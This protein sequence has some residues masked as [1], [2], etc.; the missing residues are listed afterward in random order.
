MEKF[1]HVKH[2]DLTGH[3]YVFLGNGMPSGGLTG[4]VTFAPNFHPMSRLTSLSINVTGLHWVC[5]IFI[6]RLLELETLTLVGPPAHPDRA[7]TTEYTRWWEN[8]FESSLKH[9]ICQEPILT[10]PIEKDFDYFALFAHACPNLETFKAIGKNNTV[11]KFDHRS[12]LRDFFEENGVRPLK[13]LEIWDH[14][15]DVETRAQTVHEKDFAHQAMESFRK[16]NHVERLKLDLEILVDTPEVEEVP[17]LEDQSGFF[18][19][20]SVFGPRYSHDP[21]GG[22]RAFMLNLELPKAVQSLCLREVEGRYQVSRTLVRVLKE[23]VHGNSNMDESFPAIRRLQVESVSSWL[24]VQILRLRQRFAEKGVELMALSLDGKTI[25]DETELGPVDWPVRDP[26]A[27]PLGYNCLPLSEDE[28]PIVN[29]ADHDWYGHS[30]DL[31]N[32]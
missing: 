19:M 18:T 3:G 22:V 30:D 11:G 28:V 32:Y 13:K 14:G 8:G 21:P 23:L 12:F 24:L 27:W 31:A 15:P 5:L 2:L 29:R 25:L 1:N 6:F 26:D 7:L 10:A 17:Y 16:S 4:P 9:L 20:R